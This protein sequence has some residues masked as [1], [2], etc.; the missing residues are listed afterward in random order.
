MTFLCFW[1]QTT[2]QLHFEV[3]ITIGLDI[4]IVVKTRESDRSNILPSI[5]GQE[6]ILSKANQNIIHQFPPALFCAHDKML[7]LMVDFVSVCFYFVWPM[8]IMVCPYFIRESWR[9]CVYIYIVRTIEVSS[10]SKEYH[11]FQTLRRSYV[12][13]LFSKNKKVSYVS[14]T[15]YVQCVSE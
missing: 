15:K 11:P 8:Q 9:M 7:K 1:K 14:R 12:N 2:N 3:I 5:G 6:M 13:W 10:V 4:N